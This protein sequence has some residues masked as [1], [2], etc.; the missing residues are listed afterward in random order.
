MRSKF[1]WRRKIVG[2]AP[3]ESYT[4]T[5][6]RQIARF[7]GAEVVFTEMIP[8][9]GLYRRLKPIFLKTKFRKKE[10]PI[11][12]QL[13]GGDGKVLAC[14]AQILEKEVKVDGIDLNFAC[15]V[16][17]VLKQGMG[18]YWLADPKGMFAL[19]N[20]VRR[21]ITLPLSI[22]IRAGFK[23]PT[24]ILNWVKSLNDLG[25]QAV[26]L[27]PR[28]VKQKFS[29]RADWKIFN[30]VKQKLRAKLIA[31]GDI[32]SQLDLARLFVETPVD[33]ALIARGAL[34][35]P[36]IFENLDVIKQNPREFLEKFNSSSWKKSEPGISERCQV[37]RQHFDLTKQTYGDKAWFVFRPHIF[38]YLKNFPHAK[39]W[40]IKF[41]S[42]KTTKK[43]DKLIGKLCALK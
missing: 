26:I 24:E 13:V 21:K 1:E 23:K 10:R 15:P 4:E 6:F 43:A 32:F 9:Q 17:K 2:L 36:W 3:M 5:C 41:G 39:E 34:G 38:W 30:L 12:G 33:G 20:I 18:G 40:R 37:I 19:I 31:S 25:I 28:S 35:N 29:G 14:A 16:K 27:H 8:A 22:K 7:F 11:I 42:V